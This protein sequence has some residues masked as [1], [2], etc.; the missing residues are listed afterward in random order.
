MRFADLHTH[1]YHSDGTRAPREVIDV[2]RRH[3]IE[4]VAISDHDN[5]A[6]YFEVKAYADEQSVTLI[7][8]VELSCAFEGV[9]VHILA[10]AFD[11]HDDVV[12]TRLRAFRQARERR[13]HA[14]VDRLRA[15]GYDISA[16]RVDELAAGGAVGRPHVARALVERGYAK[17]VSDAFDELIGTGK[18]GYVEKERFRLGEAISM[19]RSAGGVTS[20]AHPSLYPDHARLVAMALDAGIDAVEAVHPDVPPEDREMYTNLARFRGK[21]IT[22]GSDDHGTVKK[23]ETLGT[24]RVPET[25]IGP[26]LERL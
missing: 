3:G 14:M 23:V 20:V 8:A 7:P 22:G 24:V 17:S 10:Y 18:P 12:E 11:P 16:A 13:G 25:L 21:F 5:L 19:I 4:I 9:D 1:T 15:L 26:I 6:A 2:A